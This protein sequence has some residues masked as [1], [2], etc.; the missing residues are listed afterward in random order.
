LNHLILTQVLTLFLLMGVG[1]AARRVGCITEAVSKGLSEF[2]MSFCMPMLVLSSFLR[3]FSAGMLANAGRMLLYGLIINLMLVGLGRLLFL[4]A[5]PEKRPAL[6]F[7]T[8]FS[9]SGFMGIPLLAALF[10]IGGVFY[11]AVFGIAF[12][13]C[14]F[15]LG[16]MLFNPGGS[17]PSLGQVL[18]NP[19]ILSTFAGI[20][21]FL[22]SVRLPVP[23][24]S[25]LNLVG[26]MT[27][28]LSML[29]IGAMLGEVKLRDI[30]GGPAEYAVS[31]ARLLL[32][33]LL[34]LVVCRLLHVDPI[35]AR[36]LVILEALPAATIVAV[37]AEK[38]DGDRAFVSRCTFLTT[39]LS[40]LTIPIMVKVMERFLG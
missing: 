8:A 11:G 4:K 7:I 21:C 24:T 31:A 28:P 14:M 12:T 20:L 17:R 19:V 18:L 33:P 39:A 27:S 23:V 29:I 36:I 35:L 13:V 40:I 6:A 25:C 10:P 38:Y 15:T 32:A 34:T 3:P 26:G 30:W 22:F 37:F 16:V 2:L 9:N 5:S 1:L